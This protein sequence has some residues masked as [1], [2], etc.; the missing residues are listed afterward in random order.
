MVSTDRIKGLSSTLAVK[1]PVLAA[2]TAPITLSG[3][4]TIDG[5]AIPSGGRVLVKDQADPIENGWYDAS[6]SSWSRS[7]DANGNNDLVNGT[8][9]VVAGGTTNGAQIWKLS[10]TNRVTPGTSAMVFVSN[11]SFGAVSAFIMTLFDDADAATARATLG[12]EAA[13]ATILKDADIGVSVQAY[14]AD[15][16][17]VSASQVEMEAG[18]EANLRSMSPLRV[19]QAIAA[20]GGGGGGGSTEPTGV[21]KDYVGTT[22]PT[23]Y[24]LLSGRTIGN[25]AS[26]ATERANA[27]TSALFTLLWD[28][29]ADT[30]AAV[31]S[32][33][34]ANAAA[35]YAANKTITLPDARG[36]TIAGK[37]NMG[38]TTASRLTSSGAGIVGT[39]L[40][41]AGGT[42]THT[43]TTAQLAS[44][45]HN[46][47]ASS[48]P[49]DGSAAYGYLAAQV[50]N[51]ASGA[52]IWIN[53]TNVTNTIAIGSAGS[54]NAHQNTQPTLVLNKIIKL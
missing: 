42:Q 22:A 5:V 40:G 6:T 12:A 39:T 50:Q 30:E 48:L 54:G 17:T 4:Q 10:G 9:C 47:Y 23:G 7:I 11:L 51:S 25:A 8:L 24:V 49:S 31:S 2:T 28:S 33:R 35:D 26:G 43:L 1:A 53:S 21:V 20:L 41:V 27:D 13:D 52:S 3:L 44:H 18:T 14:D 32:G 46:L 15:I 36:R 37:D 19:A 45:G 38:G 34:G 29:M 16:P